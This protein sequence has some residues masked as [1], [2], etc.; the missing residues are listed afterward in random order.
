[1]KNV[2]R[3]FLL[4]ILLTALKT[5]GQTADSLDA[6]QAETLITEL[7]TKAMRQV[8]SMGSRVQRRKVRIW[9]QQIGSG[10]R[11]YKDK[12][13]YSLGGAAYNKR[14]YVFLTPYDEQ[15]AV[16][17]MTVMRRNNEIIWALF[18]RNDG[19]RRRWLNRRL[20]LTGY[21][22]KRQNVYQLTR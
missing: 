4:I 1:M 17:Q 14:K 11:I 7:E 8:E 3:I 12:T 13:R 15:P 5:H 16:V 19:T 21:R 9:G 10:K 18:R 20:M 2:H 22:N 6:R